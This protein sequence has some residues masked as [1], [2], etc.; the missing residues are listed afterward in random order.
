M[1]GAEL[2]TGSE[3]LGPKF[4]PGTIVKGIRHEDL[5]HLSFA[6]DSFDIIVSCEVFEHIPDPDQ[7]LA[8]TFRV[9]RPGGQLILTI[10]FFARNPA[11][12]RR[13]GLENGVLRYY[14]PK[15]FHYNPLSR[16]GSLVFTDFSWDLLARLH[17][18][19]FEDPRALYAWS[20]EC[21]HLSLTQPVFVCWKPA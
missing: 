2:V 11:S 9:L 7:G 20:A 13:A 15:E 16:N 5:Q 21:G 8:E 6:D 18:A 4:K 17:A 14:L 10:P 12:V 1:A 19:G 3:Y